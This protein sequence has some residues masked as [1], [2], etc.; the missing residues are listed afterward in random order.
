M[1][2][3]KALNRSPEVWLLLILLSLPQFSENIYS[4]ALPAI[5]H[6]LRTTHALVQWTLSIYFAGFAIGVLIWGRLSD[7]IGRK[8]SMLLGLFTYCIGTILC[9]LSNNID[10]LLLS[11]IV[12]GFGGSA[13]SVIG[14]AMARGSL[15]DHRRH[16]FF[17]MSGFALAFSITLGPF[18]G[19]YLTQWLH[20][21][22][23]F[24]FLS[25]IGLIIFMIAWLQLPSSTHSPTKNSQ[26][27]FSSVAKRLLKDRR[28]IYCACLVG[29]A[30]G[31]LFSYYAEAP[32]IF[33]KLLKLTPSQ[34]GKLG[35]FIALAALLGSIFSRKLAKRLPQKTV[36]L[37]GGLT[38][39]FSSLL[40]FML[41]VCGLVSHSHV[42]ISTI[43]MVLPMMGIVFAAYG[44]ITPIALGTALLD[45]NDALGTAGALFGLSYYFMVSLFTWLMGF[46]NNGTVYPMPIYFLILSGLVLLIVLNLRKLD[47]PFS[48]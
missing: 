46:F 9:L 31:L 18:I 29:I 20:W 41:T 33:I 27:N 19:G 3:S 40:L 42:F 47:Q 10:W 28:V 37:I 12:Q 44:F 4:P 23:N 36:I 35:L 32:F 48:Q 1:V 24:A 7:Q 34:F 5:S 25:I 21:Q 30:Q 8:K 43:A 13:C 6:N 14:Q 38:I 39:A 45:Y 11:R 2:S 26:S 16:Q 17:S 15:S 22:S